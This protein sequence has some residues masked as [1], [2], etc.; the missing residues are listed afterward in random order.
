MKDK[1]HVVY[2]VDAVTEGV[3]RADIKEGYGACDSIGVVSM[4][5]GASGSTGFA[6]IGVD[7]IDGRV[8]GEQDWFKAWCVLASM[9][10]DASKLSEEKRTFCGSVFEAISVAVA[11][12]KKAGTNGEAS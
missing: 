12:A 4:V 1:F 3:Q 11:A 6:F 8:W 2:K 7:G 5:H 10:K 9:L